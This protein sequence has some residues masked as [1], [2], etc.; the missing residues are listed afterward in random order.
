MSDHASIITDRPWELTIKT[1]GHLGLEGL[2]LLGGT[3]AGLIAH[4]LTSPLKGAIEF[5]CELGHDGDVCLVVVIIV[6]LASS[7][8]S[9]CARVSSEQLGACDGDSGERERREEAIPE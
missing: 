9:Q 1:E 7:W 8:K 4:P 3:R 5:L 6:G 2:E